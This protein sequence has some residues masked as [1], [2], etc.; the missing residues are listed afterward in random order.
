MNRASNTFRKALRQLNLGIETVEQ[1]EAEVIDEQN[2]LGDDLRNLRTAAMI[3]R[4]AIAS[5]LGIDGMQLAGI[6]HRS[7]SD[8][9]KKYREAV[10]KLYESCF[11]R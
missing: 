6:E 4:K 11:G 3:P 8:T 9:A 10:I 2:D 7:N 1:A 5:N